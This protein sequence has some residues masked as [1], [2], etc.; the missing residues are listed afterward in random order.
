MAD[1]KQ[2]LSYKAVKRTHAQTFR[3]LPNYSE[4]LLRCSMPQSTSCCQNAAPA[5]EEKY[6][7]AVTHKASLLGEPG[8]G[9]QALFFFAELTGQNDDS[10]PVVSSRTPNA[11][12]C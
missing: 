11:T 1:V 5:E 12:L 6:K 10:L 2:T 8:V 7:L 9:Y 4:F 3:G